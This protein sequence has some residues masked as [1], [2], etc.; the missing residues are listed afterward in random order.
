MAG[1]EVRILSRSKTVSHSD[2]GG[3]LP[4]S[5]SSSVMK[6]NF[7]NIRGLNA[8]LNSVHQHLQSERPHILALTETQI[9][10]SSNQTHLPCPGYEL[11]TKFS[12]K[13]GTC[14]FAR[15]DLACQR[16]ESLERPDFDTLWVKIITPQLTKFLC[17]L[18]L[19]PNDS[20]YKE[21]F[22]YLADT[23]DHLQ[24]SYPNSEVIFLG[25]FNVHNPSW[26]KF[27]SRINEA[28]RRAEEFAISCNLTQLVDVPTRIPDRQGDDAH[29]LDLFLTTHPSLYRISTT[30]PLGKS[31]HILLKTSYK[32]IMPKHTPPPPRK[33]WHFKSADW[34]EL[35]NFFSSFP[36]NDVCFSSTNVSICAQAV[37][38]V[39][40]LG[41]E[42]FIPHSIKTFSSTKPWFGKACVRALAR[43]R[44]SFE[45]WRKNPSSLNRSAYV[46]ARNA[47][48]LVID[49]AKETFCNKIKNKLISCPS[50]SRSF[51]SLSK[52]V[53][54]NFTSSAFPPLM[55]DDGSIATTAKEKANLF[56]KI[57]SNNSTLDSQGKIPPS[58]PQQS[59][60]MPNIKFHQKTIR[61][62]LRELDT[63]KAVGV[64]GIPPIVLK[65]CANELAPTLCKI[66]SLSYEQGVFPEAWK[67][68]R[69]Q[70]IPK[71]GKK[72][73]PSNYRPI[74]LLST[75]SK[76]MEKA[77]NIQLVKYLEDSKLISDHQFGFRQQRSTGDLLTYVT[78][79][80]TSTLENHGECRA[81]SLDISKAFDRVWHEA[82]LSKLS[83]YGIPS[84]LCQWVSSFLHGRS[85]QVVVDGVTSDRYNTNAGVPQ[86][87]I[88]S[89]TLFLIFINDL[90]SST[91]N[92]IIS[93]ADDATLIS[94]FSS[95]RPLSASSTSNLRKE[96]VESINS[97]LNTILTWGERNLVQFNP[98]KTQASTF[99]RKRSTTA[100]DIVMDGT[101]IRARESISLLGITISDNLS[102][103]SHVRNLAKSASQKLGSLFRAKNLYSSPQLAQIYKAQIRPTVEYCSHIWRTAPAHTLNLLDSIERRAMKL[104]N[105]PTLLHPSQTLEHRRNVG[106]LCLFYRYFNG[107]CADS[108][109][110]IVPSLA[111]FSRNTRFSQASHRFTVALPTCRTSIHK[112]S[113][114]N[115][116][117]YMWNSLPESLFPISYNMNSFKSTV[118]RH[119]S[120][121]PNDLVVR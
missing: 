35:R 77:I 114:M 85:L 10:P 53:S 14:L 111:S 15:A 120:Q 4:Q 78:D 27:S 41:I 1:S 92:P 105:D 22:D 75:I 66:F 23:F 98:D 29:I 60:K 63:N 61:H 20:R 81:V 48:K 30:A 51:W 2:F 33:I 102:W 117:A 38:E 83:S 110:N 64:D 108:I 119:L 112:G 34:D 107:R 55:R 44:K 73:L 24:T 36:W 17:C 54:K 25:D 47:C 43:K 65:M 32:F 9:H 89:P 86:G 113:F 79:L 70:P 62:I 95:M 16:E 8:N 72:N 13:R 6:T 99:S 45:V 26:L 91:Q 80:L 104:V 49:Q 11:F 18:Y 94:S 40:T 115:R 118:H 12:F 67:I 68:A 46:Q 19:S 57:F 109:S 7:C 56:A 59:F 90:L 116:A 76:V 82:L 100:P 50:G 97:D 42:T 103:D 93:Y 74:S 37:G 106:D 52:A 88:L 87:S 5:G 58:I 71:K 96:Q 39:I 69:V 3:K 28:G 84:Q 101:T 21:L 31:D 121:I